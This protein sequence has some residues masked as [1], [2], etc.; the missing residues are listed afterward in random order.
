MDIN[1]W[2][3]FFSDAILQAQQDSMDLIHFLIGKSKMLTVLKDQLNPRQEKA[4]LRIFAEGLQGFKGGLSA[5]NYIAITKVSR[6]TTTRDLT[7]LV[8]KGA[9]IKTGELRHTRYWLNFQ[10]FQ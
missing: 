9:L 6:A 7:D 4:L 10:H 5:N 3:N 8:Q 1:P 2:V